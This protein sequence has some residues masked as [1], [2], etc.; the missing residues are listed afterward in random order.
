MYI[1]IKETISI[2]I[3]QIAICVINSFHI[4]FIV[5]IN[6]ALTMTMSLLTVIED[7]AGMKI[8]RRET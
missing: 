7:I 1:H 8:N 5:D 4:D 3:S 6:S 2:N